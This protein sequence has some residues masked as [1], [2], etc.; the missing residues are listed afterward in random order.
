MTPIEKRSYK[1]NRGL[2]NQ[3]GDPIKELPVNMVRG[4]K[5]ISEEWNKYPKVFTP[6]VA[7]T[8]EIPGNNIYNIS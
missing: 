1:R 8:A 4:W 2:P 3:A 7:P 6:P 5:D